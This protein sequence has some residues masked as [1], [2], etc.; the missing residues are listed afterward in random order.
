LNYGAFDT[1]YYFGSR[2]GFVAQGEA[3]VIASKRI[4]PQVDHALDFPELVFQFGLAGEIKVDGK[5]FHQ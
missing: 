1:V 3:N 5:G 2:F 4:N